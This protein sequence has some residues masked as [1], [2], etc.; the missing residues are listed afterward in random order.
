MYS[1][2]TKD[3]RNDD[4]AIYLLLVISETQILFDIINTV[5]Q[6]YKTCYTLI[7]SLLI[8]FLRVTDD[9][10][11]EYLKFAY[12]FPVALIVFILFFLYQSPEYKTVPLQ[13]P[14]L[15]KTVLG[16]KDRKIILVICALYSIIAFY[17]LGNTQ[18]PESFY[19][20]NKNSVTLVLSEPQQIAKITYFSGI[21]TG[22]YSI[23]ASGEDGV[24]HQIG[25]GKQS[26]NDVLKWNEFTLD[27]YSNFQIKYIKIEADSDTHMGELGIYNVN[28][29]LCSVAKT[30]GMYNP[31]SLVD[32]QQ[33]VPDKQDYMNSSY[34]DEIYHVR[35]AIEYLEN[36]SPYEISHPPLGKEIISIGIILF[37][38]SPFGWR[39]MGTLFGILMLPFLYYFLKILFGNIQVA[40][41]GTI[42]FAFD[43]MHFVQTR[44][45]TIDT[46]AVFFIILMNLFMYLYLIKG[47][48]RYLGVCG[49]CFGIGVACKWTCLYAGSGLA[50]IWLLHWIN[51][52]HTGKRHLTHFIK[53]CL[54]CLLFFIIIPACIYYLS[55]IPYGKAAGMSGLS[56][57]FSKDYL[58][59][60]VDNQKFMYTYHSN[61]HASHPYS[62]R[63]YQWIFDIRPILYY[64]EYSDDLQTISSFGAFVN[65]LLCWSGLIAIGVM[66]YFSLWRKDRRATFILIGYLAQLI[67]WIIITRTTFEYH[68][69]GCTVFL[70]LAISYIFQ[71]MRVGNKKWKLPV[72]AYT[73]LSLLLFIQ[74]YPVLTGIP[75]SSAYS[76]AFLSWLPSWPF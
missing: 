54:Y 13:E 24:Y 76:N 15:K 11:R 34:F 28:N 72:F 9:S 12:I 18:S 47:K 59:I 19:V 30:Y 62:S 17:G 1:T 49:I 58:K 26:Y 45:A 41:A 3:I 46:Y 20:F 4:L 51:L 25:S 40:S 64:L 70:V 8:Y 43:F 35:T 21:N 60:V 52:L 16:I 68:Y 53:N 29:S 32:E 22:N 2:F 31:D 14:K 56:M 71:T 27:N 42:I 39:F 37:G 63:W 44:I 23:Y 50:V 57:L 5:L 6:Q 74:F 61:V 66:F 69:F 38:Y 48:T 73:I 65:P 55:Y 36:I 7:Y 33:L 67:P 10:G 75:R